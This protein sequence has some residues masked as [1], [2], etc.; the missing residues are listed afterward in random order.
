MSFVSL[1]VRDQLVK[2]SNP[3]KHVRGQPQTQF[4]FLELSLK[5]LT[6]FILIFDDQMTG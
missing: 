3:N 2:S 4:T 5:I 1:K 6:Y